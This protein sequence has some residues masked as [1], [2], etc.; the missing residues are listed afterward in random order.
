MTSSTCLVRLGPG[1][2]KPLTPP[3]LEDFGFTV[4]IRQ[5]I[6]VAQRTVPQ[7]SQPLALAVGIWLRRAPRGVNIVEL[8]VGRGL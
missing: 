4:V 6:A 5:E 3:E 8:K 1:D 7:F 2:H